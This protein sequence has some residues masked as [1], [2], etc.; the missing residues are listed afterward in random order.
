M[1][2]SNENM[3]LQKM[4]AV[5]LRVYKNRTVQLQ[6]FEPT[7]KPGWPQRSQLAHLRTNR[8]VA[9]EAALLTLPGL[10]NCI[11]PLCPGTLPSLM[12]AISLETNG[13]VAT[14][15]E[16]S[17]AIPVLHI[18]ACVVLFRNVPLNRRDTVFEMAPATV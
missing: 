14:A 1:D 6:Y 7:L 4:T 11:S 2:F 3:L 8:T 9:F 17:A 10:S 18:C 5:K 12:R 16:C 15:V 13:A